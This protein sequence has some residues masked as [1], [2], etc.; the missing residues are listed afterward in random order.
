MQPINGIVF[1]LDGILI[2]A[3]D[4]TFLAWA[5]GLAAAIFIPLAVAVP[6]IGLGLGWLWGTIWVLMV[7]R[8][9]G[10]LWRFRSNRWVVL[11]TEN[12]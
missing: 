1:A 3:G 5:M 10:V 7:V 9:A 12:A 2:G 8:A 4:M 11:G 6:A